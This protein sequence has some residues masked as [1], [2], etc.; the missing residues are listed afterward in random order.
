MKDKNRDAG[1]SVRVLNQASAINRSNSMEFH[2]S[3]DIELA[4]GEKLNRWPEAW[5][6]LRVVARHLE[7]VLE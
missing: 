5:P 3:A 7:K 1:K 4:A 2:V 6:L